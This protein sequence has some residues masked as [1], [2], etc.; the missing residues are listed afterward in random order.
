LGARQIFISIGIRHRKLPEKLIVWLIMGMG[1]FNLAVAH[2][3]TQE[4]NEDSWH[5]LQLFVVDGIYFR[6]FNFPELAEHK[7]P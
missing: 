6:T 7:T 5:G 1:L 3:I 4:D 2:L